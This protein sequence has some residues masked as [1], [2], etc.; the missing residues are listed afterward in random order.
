MCVLTALGGIVVLQGQGTFDW[1]NRIPG[2]LLAPIYGA[3]PSSPTA[4]RSGNTPSGLPAGT[5]TYHGPLL[6]GLG[7]SAQL[8][9]G[10]AGT[11]E[12]SLVPLAALPAT[13]GTGGNAGY[14]SAGQVALPGIGLGQTVAAQLRVW[15]NRAGSVGTWN[16]ALADPT[17]PRGASAVLSLDLSSF[18]PGQTPYL[19][20]LESFQL[21]TV[22]EPAVF[23]LGLGGAGMLLALRGRR[24]RGE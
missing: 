8:Y 17:V 19:G 18:L 6:A 22:P 15:D 9:F 3:D 23:P 20:G 14:Y 16:A 21:R 24:T 13:F 5:Q 12:S 10:P 2:V 7:F 11:P 4:F 1:G